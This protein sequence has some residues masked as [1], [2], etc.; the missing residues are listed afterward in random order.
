MADMSERDIFIAALQ[1]PKGPERV[2]FLAEACRSQP[3]LQQQIAALLDEHDHLGDFLD[4]P[5]FASTVHFDEP[6]IETLGTLI[7]PY[8]LLEQIGEGGMG[9]VF[10]ADQLQPV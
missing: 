4:A 9:L 6:L 10:M 7:G 3:G 8:N 1:Q 5:A 2:A